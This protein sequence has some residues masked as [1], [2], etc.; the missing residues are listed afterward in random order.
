MKS[1]TR[2]GVTIG[3]GWDDDF[4]PTSVEYPGVDADATISYTSREATLTHGERELRLTFDAWGRLGERREKVQS[5]PQVDATT[6]YSQFDAK[7]RPERGTV[8]PLLRPMPSSTT[9]KEVSRRH[10]PRD[11]RTYTYTANA[12][13]LHTRETQNGS[14]IRSEFAGLS[15]PTTGGD[16]NSNAVSITYAQRSNAPVGIQQSITAS[17]QALHSL[18]RDLLG[19]VVAEDHPETGSITYPI[20]REGWIEG[21][22]KPTGDYRYD[23]DALGRVTGIHTNGG[24][25]F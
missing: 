14:V 4:R 11:E 17:G 5:R 13:G 24:G 23:L 2:G 18:V 19:V 7:D 25:N 21:V 1:E 20:T 22:I 15:G 3:Y 16:I 8:P 12:A 10:A 6:S 9:L